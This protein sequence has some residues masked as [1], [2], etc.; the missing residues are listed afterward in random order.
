MEYLREDLD[1]NPIIVVIREDST[2]PSVW[3][4]L[5]VYYEKKFLGI[6]YR[7]KAYEKNK[8]VDECVNFS[9]KNFEI[10]A[11]H[12]VGRYNNHITSIRKNKAIRQKVRSGECG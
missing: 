11:N 12:F 2:F 9:C 3:F 8:L 1:G 6:K 4:N 7:S 5:I 10:T